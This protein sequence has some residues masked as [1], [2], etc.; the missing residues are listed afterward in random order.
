MRAVM[1]INPGSAIRDR[2]AA[3]ASMSTSLTFGGSHHPKPSP[4]SRKL[5]R[6][7]RSPSEAIASRWAFGSRTRMDISPPLRL[8]AST[9]RPRLDEGSAVP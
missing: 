7:V 5:L 4:A 6:A 8:R 1:M 2:R 9:P 3:L